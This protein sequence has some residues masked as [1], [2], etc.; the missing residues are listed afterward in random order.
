M[1]GQAF[2]YYAKHPKLGA[3]VLLA[4]LA[5]EIKTSEET[6]FEE[7]AFLVIG[8]NGKPVNWDTSRVPVRR[9]DDTRIEVWGNMSAYVSEIKI[10]QTLVS[11]ELNEISKA[12]QEDEPAEEPSQEDVIAGERKEEPDTSEELPDHLMG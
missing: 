6:G 11:G 3:I 7:A 5:T 1:L 12:D 9:H 2:Y 8:E 4:I 10:D